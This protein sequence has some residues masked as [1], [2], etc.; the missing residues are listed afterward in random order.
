[1]RKL[2]DRSGCGVPVLLVLSGGID[3]LIVA[4]TSLLDAGVQL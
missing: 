3:A 4:A 2:R 1:M